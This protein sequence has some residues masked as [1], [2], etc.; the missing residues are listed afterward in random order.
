MFLQVTLVLIYSLKT[1]FGSQQCTLMQRAEP[2]VVDCY[3]QLEESS[4]YST[5]VLQAVAD[6]KM[7]LSLSNQRKK[8][9]K[10]NAIPSMLLS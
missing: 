2:S 5:S 8:H 1:C 7:S 6:N 3:N 10:P 9:L 4:K